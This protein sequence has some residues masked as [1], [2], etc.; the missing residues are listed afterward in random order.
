MAKTMNA[1]IK[2][3][4]HKHKKMNYLP[5]IVALLHTF[6]KRFKWHIH[7]HV[8]ITAGGLDLDNKTW[9]ENDYL[10]EESLKKAWK[11]KLLAGIRKL[12]RKGVLKDAYGNKGKSFLQM[13]SSLHDKKWYVWL[14]RVDN[15]PSFSFIY[16][17]RYAKR[18]PIS[19]KGILDYREGKEIVWKERARIEAPKHCANRAHPH[20]FIE[21][22]IQH[23]PDKYEHQVFYYGLYS[24]YHKNRLYQVA[25]RI[26]D[27]RAQKNI[28][29]SLSL[30][31]IKLTFSRLMRW[32]H[33][34]DPLACPICGKPMQLT[35]IIFLSRGNPSDED[36][37][38]NYEIKN[39]QLVKKTD[40]S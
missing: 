22:L 24:S 15:D 23:I 40:S 20:E 7:F 36:L 14:K 6:G 37:L 27:K 26:L 31:R 25:K 8:L 34:H 13:L 12:Y 3:F 21:L 19:Q 1:S 17:S 9:T 16:I 4:I 33:G 10:N 5:G 18:A 30:K 39:Y 11:A 29:I 35:G 28:S 38:L 2:Q 32:T